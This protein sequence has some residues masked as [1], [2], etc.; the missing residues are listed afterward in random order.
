MGVLW[1]INAIISSTLPPKEA[2]INW[3]HFWGLHCGIIALIGFLLFFISPYK[4]NDLNK[5]F[6]VIIVLSI[7]TLYFI[8][9]SAIFSRYSAFPINSQILIE[10]SFDMFAKE[11]TAERVPFLKKNFP[12]DTIPVFLPAVISIPKKINSFIFVQATSPQNEG[13]NY[14]I[15]RIDKAYYGY[16]VDY[17]TFVNNGEYSG[18]A[19]SVEYKFVYYHF[20]WHCERVP[21]PIE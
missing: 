21:R 6:I 5:Y 10:R 4:K 12:S 11:V 1:L 7:A 15:A 19:E 13:K 18:I 8:K 2:E 9:G 14:Y 3:L 20:A 16:H 17:F